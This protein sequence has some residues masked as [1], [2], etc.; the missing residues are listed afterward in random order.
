M[1][2]EGAR[3]DC[4]IT[5]WGQFTEIKDIKEDMLARLEV[6]FDISI[7]EC[8]LTEAQAFIKALL[9]SGESR[10]VRTKTTETSALT[11]SVRRKASYNNTLLL[12]THVKGC[13]EIV[14]EVY[15]KACVPID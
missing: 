1:E 10:K 3:K 13:R 2:F 4:D 5:R 7:T 14:E 8:G 12:R 6:H 9:T 11:V 15:L